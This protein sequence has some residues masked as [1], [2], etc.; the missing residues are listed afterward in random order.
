[1][2]IDKFSDLLWSVKNTNELCSRRK[3]QPDLRSEIGKERKEELSRWEKETNATFGYG[4][5]TRGAFTTFLSMC[6]DIGKYI[7]EAC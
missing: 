2:E 5:I 4:E 7:K 3:G 6:Q 1:M